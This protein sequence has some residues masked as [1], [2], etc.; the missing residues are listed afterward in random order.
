MRSLY[1]KFSATF[2]TI[3]LIVFIAGAQ[4]K[5]KGIITALANGDPLIGATVEESG[6]ENGTISDIDGSFSFSVSNANAILLIKY[7]GYDD[8]SVN[9]A[10]QNDINVSLTESSVMI[11]QIVVVGYGTQKKSDLTGAVSSLKGSELERV[12]TPNVEQAL[13]GKIPC[14]YV[15]PASGQPGSG[16]VIR[17]RGTGTL[18]NSNPLYVIDGMITEDASSV[19]P[20]DVESIEVLKDASSAAI[21]GSRGA[22]GVIIITTKNGKKRKNAQLSF[23]TYYG[24]QQAVN[25]ISLLNGTQFA[26]AYNQLRGINYFTNPDSLGEGTNW[27]AEVLRNAPIR[28]VQFGA[29]GASDNIAYNFSANYFNQDGILKN[30]SFERGTFRLNTEMKLKPWFT[31]GNNVSYSLI[32][33]HLGPNVISSAYRIPSVLPVYD[34][35]GNFT[36]P[37]FYGLAVA[38]PAADQFYKSNNKVKRTNLLGNVYGE[39]SFLQNFRFRTNFGYN[40]TVESSRYFEPK[41][42]VSASQ[43]NKSDRLNI[44]QGSG[45]NWIWEQTLNYYKEWTDH[46]LGVLIGYTAEERKSEN[47]GA[48]RESFPGS[49]DELIYLSSGN[50][51]TQ[52]NFGGASDE[53]MTSILFRTNYSFKEK[54]L[55]TTSIRVDKSSRFTPDHRTGYFPAA[56]V[57]WNMGRESFI[58]ELNTFDRLKVRLSYGILGNQALT[59][60]YPTSAIIN[61]GLGAVFGS[62]ENLNQGATQLSISNPKLKWEVSNQIDI[63]LEAGFLNNRLDVEVDWYK[64]NTYDII[65]AVPIPDFVG[66]SSSP[67]VNT[68]EVLNS[69]VDIGVNWRQSG[70]FDYNIGFNISPVSNEV[71]ALAKGRNEIFDAFINGEPATHTIVGLPIGA[72]YGFRTAGVF[73]TTEEISSSPKL[74]GEKPG[75]LR[76]I[77]EDNNGL[78]DGNDRVY[79]GSPIPTLTY[80]INLGAGYKGFDMN[81]DFLGVS[82]NKVFNEKES[83]RFGVYN[84]ESHVADAW[85]TTNP[86]DSEPRVT[87]GGHNFRVSDRFIQDGSFFRLRTVNLGYSIPNSILSKIKM[88]SLRIFVSGTNLWTQQSF[89]GY[90]P[91]FPNSTSPFKVGF[92]NGTYPIAKSIQFGL[93]TKF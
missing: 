44:T 58:E 34:E 74:G 3:F 68:A 82:G 42:T 81:I 36:D 65:A 53:A 17:V 64:R 20:Q 15:S 11:D 66:S 79:L 31:L 93:E 14:V 23:S 69:G 18:N 25:Q 55:F 32:Q 33:E 80:G 47:I 91:E 56:S 72:Y 78:I 84:W 86:S 49:S 46:S 6:T 54:Y 10:G 29:N 87:N 61:G 13:Q 57:G 38:N 16:A 77:D 9:V 41:F 62:G 12:V 43:L 24:Q 21:Y 30:T 71:L 90:S 89:T 48:S 92:D 76:Y 52:M 73:Q 59:D 60:R 19:N 70:T 2:I 83:F 26:R 51:T 1:Q 88:E 7:I 35:D 5:V 45:K 50:D 27:Q 8:L 28:N 85:T 75:D 40:F 4:H 22:N 37:T 63:G 39:V 67:Y